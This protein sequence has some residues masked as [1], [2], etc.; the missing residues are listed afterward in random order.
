M[1]KGKLKDIRKI[2]ANER[3]VEKVLSA[4]AIYVGPDDVGLTLELKFIKN[5]STDE[6]Q[7]VIR[8][9]EKNVREKYPEIKK[10]F[11]EAAS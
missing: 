5:I 7:S 6:L 2:A 4:L 1:E 10:V 3:S 11:Y 9:I 8:R